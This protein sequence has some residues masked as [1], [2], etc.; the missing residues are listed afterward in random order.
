MKVDILTVEIGSTTTVVSGFRIGDRPALMVQGEHYTTV[1]EGDV[2]LGIDRAVRSIE[3]KIGEH[4]EWDRMMAS[5]SA[6]GGLRMTVHGL[7]YSMT[8]KAAKEA[9]LGAG[10]VIA[11][12]TAGKISDETIEEVK[13]ISPKLILISEGVDNGESETALYN[14]EL[15]ARSDI[16]VPFLYAGNSAVASKVERIFKENGKDITVTENVYP[17][18]DL[19]NVGPVRKIIQ[20]LFSK[21]IIHG[22]GMSKLEGQVYG[23]IVPT[24]AAV[25]KAVEILQQEMGDALAIDIGGATT[26]VDSV[27][28]G[29]SDIQKILVSPEPFAKRTVE[30][31]LGVFINASNV[32]K[33]FEWI[34]EKFEDHESLLKE[35]TP[36][37]SNGRMEEFV[38]TLAIACAT[39]SVLR[40]AGHK[41]YL[42]GPTGRIEIAEGK[43]LTAIVNIF[44]TG[45]VLSRSK[46]NF[47]ILNEI[48]NLRSRHPMN[49]LP[50]AEANIYFDSNYIF[51]PCGLIS[52]IDQESAKKLLLEDVKL[53][54]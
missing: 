44:G 46:W 24:P 4:L 20:D 14:S 31:D 19:L 23:K 39:E 9:A 6:A 50:P 7:V 16:N 28:A 30:G 11:M 48:R 5:S 13:K 52:Q 3:K 42:Y 41:R 35:I 33:N 27:T 8:V 47:K 32:V 36:Y 34:K 12:A 17:R 51:A 21:H 45:G 53:A 1:K 54:K 49:L 29:S 40:H 18:V 10:A 25:M 43:D 26:D 37:P 22:P 15:F 38:S 2:T